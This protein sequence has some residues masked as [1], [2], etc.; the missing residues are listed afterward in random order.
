MQLSGQNFRSF[1]EPCLILRSS[2]SETSLNQKKKRGLRCGFKKHTELY[3]SAMKEIFFDFYLSLKIH[4]TGWYFSAGRL[5]TFSMV[6]MVTPAAMDTIRLL[7]S[8]TRSI[9]FS[10]MGTMWGFTASITNWLL[11]TTS[12]LSLAIV[13]PKPWK[14]QPLKVKN[15]AIYKT[16][17]T[18]IMQSLSQ[19]DINDSNIHGNSS[20]LGHRPTFGKNV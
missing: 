16:D 12:R 6:D 4:L 18:L 9:S 8:T 13:T 14:Y 5:L 15:F 17:M 2:N 11:L 7:G 10:T 1:G 20:T 3:V 19:A